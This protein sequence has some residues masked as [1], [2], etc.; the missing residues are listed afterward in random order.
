ME[1]SIDFLWLKNIKNRD[2]EV[3]ASVALKFFGREINGARQS[4]LATTVS[5][6]SFDINLLV[7]WEIR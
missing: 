2:S 6:E 1:R 7:I 3:L 5:W 4:S